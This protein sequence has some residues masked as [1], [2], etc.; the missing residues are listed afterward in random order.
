LI[1]PMFSP[2]TL[3]IWSRTLMDPLDI[4]CVQLGNFGRT[5]GYSPPIIG[6]NTHIKGL[7]SQDSKNITTVAN[8]DPRSYAAG[9]SL[10]GPSCI[11][12]TVYPSANSSAASTASIPATAL[13][14]KPKSPKPANYMLLRAGY[15]QQAILFAPY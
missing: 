6:S 11:T 7:L 14:A 10:R 4:S 8:L 9:K 13:P 3:A 1:R 5:Q 2:S 15:E 12:S